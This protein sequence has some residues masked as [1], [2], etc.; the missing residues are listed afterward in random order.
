MVFL[1]Q[2]RIQERGMSGKFFFVLIFLFVIVS[3]AWVY[4]DARKN[5]IG[6]IPDDSSK[7]NRTAGGW[8]AQGL[9]L[10]LRSRKELLNRAAQTPVETTGYRGIFVLGVLTFAWL[11]MA[12]SVFK[13]GA[14]VTITAKSTAP[15]SSVDAKDATLFR[16]FKYG[17][18][19]RDFPVGSQYEDCSADIGQSARC[20]EEI[21][22][23]GEKYSAAFVFSDNELASVSLVANYSEETYR[24]VM[25]SLP[26]NGFN[27]ALMQGTTGRLDLI[28]TINKE[29]Q[30]AFVSK[31]SG[32]ES[33]NLQSGR[34]TY[35]FVE[36]PGSELKEYKSA[37]D[38]VTKMP[39]K[40]RELDFTVSENDGAASIILKFTLPRLDIH[41]MSTSGK[42][43]T[44]KF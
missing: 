15:I 22:F 2:D 39:V 28:E 33:V 38:A 10:Y 19:I 25:A 29:G 20:V 36:L 30:S 7:N 9:I 26:K 34:L 11:L 3:S 4:R 42:A 41:K 17:Q 12:S 1:N 23:M 16:Q 8:A 21:E 14:M 18:P 35:I 24:K 5:K 6:K 44:E 13:D 40:T 43:S 37:V 27:L 31:I 32:F